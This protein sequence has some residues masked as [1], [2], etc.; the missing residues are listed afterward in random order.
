MQ[1]T[2]KDGNIPATGAHTQFKDHLRDKMLKRVEV[3]V[4]K[5][6]GPSWEER[7]EK[8]MKGFAA[9]ARVL[10]GEQKKALTESIERG[11]S[12][13]TSAPTR[14]LSLSPNQQAMLR[15]RQKEMAQGESDYK[16]QMEN[17]KDKMQK[18]EPLYRLSEVNAAFAMQR[19][20]MIQKK[21]EMAQDEHERWEH[22][23]TMEE[24]AS[25]RPL[26]I[27]ESGLRAP[28]KVAPPS[29]PDTAP[30][31]KQ[32]FD[33]SAEKSGAT[34]FFGK[35]E[36]ECDTRIRSAWANEVAS[37]SSWAMEVARIKDKVNN[38][39]KLHEETYPNRGDSR[40]L[41]RSRL[42]HSSA[43]QVHR[44]VH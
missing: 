12:R 22:L 33:D 37:G 3:V 2:I 43:P 20:R 13:P 15:Q 4:K 11:R 14:L 1:L 40:A 25:E 36:Y 19:Q 39:L 23:R 24:R 10:E 31:G 35:E 8:S 38:R 28:K 18:R 34:E 21:A 32:E 41:A 6:A 5:R 42:M 17:L 30:A 7:M 16:V 29:R 44:V 27:E 9:K 26:L